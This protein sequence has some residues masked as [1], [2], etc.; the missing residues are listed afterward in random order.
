VAGRGEFVAKSVL[1]AAADEVWEFTTTAAGINAELMPIA[2]M[3]VPRGLGEFDITNVTA[4]AR[5]GRSWILLGGLIPFDYDDIFI[6]SLEPGR[7]FYERST[8]LTQRSWHHDRVVQ[9]AGPDTCFVTDSV[10]FEPRLPIPPRFLTP[11][12]RWVFRHRHRRL[13]KR[14]GGSA[15]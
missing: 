1:H 5:L 13:R 11:V 12:F 14:F 8:M 9:P 7:A 15:G 4:P 2:R 3:T 10:S 6:E